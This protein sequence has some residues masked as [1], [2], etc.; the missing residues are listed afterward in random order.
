[1][2]LQRIKPYVRLGIA[3]LLSSLF[4]WNCAEEK[5]FATLPE[6][7]GLFDEHH[8][9][10]RVV[11]KQH[12]PKPIFDFIDHR[13]L[14][15]HQ[16]V[17]NKATEGYVFHSGNSRNNVFG[18]VDDSKSVVVSL[19][20]QTRYTFLVRPSEPNT[21]EVINLVVIDDGIQT[22]EY[23][24][25]YTFDS[26]SQVTSAFNT[27]DMME[28]EGTIS[29]Y[30]HEGVLI[31]DYTMSQ[32]RTTNSTGSGISCDPNDDTS[33]DP[34]DDDSSSDGS[35]GNGGCSNCGGDGDGNYEDPGGGN[36]D[37]STGGG[38]EFC[39]VDIEYYP[40]KCGGDANG[41]PP[42]GEDCCQGSPMTVTISCD[43][44][45]GRNNSSSDLA[46]FSCDSPVGAIIEKE[47]CEEVT[48]LVTDSIFLEKMDELEGTLNLP[49]ETGYAQEYT[50]EY[51]AMELVSNDVTK[52]KF[53]TSP[54]VIGMMHNHSGPV[55]DIDP[56][57]GELKDYWSVNMYSPE[58]IGAF[59]KTAS[60][61]DGTNFD[62]S[63]AY[64]ALVTF[65]GNYIL[66]FKGNADDVPTPPDPGD[67]GVK[68]LYDTYV[69]NAENQAQG[70]LFFLNLYGVNN[71]VIYE[72]NA[73]GAQIGRFYDEEGN[74]TIIECL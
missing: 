47:D 3:L 7:F 1:M 15:T 28:F 22:I 30:N 35:S 9:K 32:G 18:T 21:N 39:R 56:D 38:G 27:I 60:N 5:D 2:K 46:P 16:I 54:T 4:L 10:V 36:D 8:Q 12:I 17:L 11:K 48:Q 67:K 59:L 44:W 37:G 45:G 43:Q 20:T 71:V 50:G 58:D 24:V 23:F 68:R 40:C 70:L 13:T 49:H 14:G 61:G 19:D 6:A 72:I 31:G 73:L 63:E 26:N 55:K 62:A 57:T 52:L 25:K 74:Y 34:N 33:D 69:T 53:P 65:E 66:K 41:H 64:S 29:F 42:S 51:N